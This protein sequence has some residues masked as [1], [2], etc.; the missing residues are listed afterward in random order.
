MITWPKPPH[1]GEIHIL[2]N[3]KSR[4]LLRR[5]PEILIVAAAQLFLYNCLHIVAERSKNR[6]QRG[7]QILVQLDSHQ[8]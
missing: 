6:R 3:E 4:F 8:A 2:R 1:V 5:F 7:G